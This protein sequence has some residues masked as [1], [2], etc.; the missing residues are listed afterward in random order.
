MWRSCTKPPNQYSSKGDLGLNCFN[1]CQYVHCIS[2]YTLYDIIS[3]SLSPS[4]P[5]RRQLIENSAAHFRTIE[6]LLL[7]GP[8]AAPPTPEAPPPGSNAPPPIINRK[9]KPPIRECYI[10][11]RRGKCLVPKFKVGG[12]PHTREGKLTAER[13]GGN[14]SLGGKTPAPPPPPRNNTER[15]ALGRAYY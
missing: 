4:L 9:L 2:G 10:T 14:Q 3:P 11:T 1:S 12:Q 13:K 15:E 6:I 8:W 7:K 5:P